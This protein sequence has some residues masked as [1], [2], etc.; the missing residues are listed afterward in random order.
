MRLSFFF[1]LLFISFYLSAQA[2]PKLVLKEKPLPPLGTYHLYIEPSTPRYLIEKA[3]SK[4]WQVAFLFDQ[5]QAAWLREIIPLLNG[6]SPLI[7]LEGTLSP[8]EEIR[9]RETLD[10]FNYEVTLVHLK[11]K[12]DD[13]L[14]SLPFKGVVTLEQQTEKGKTV[15]TLRRG[16]QPSEQA[17]LLSP[18]D[19]RAFGKPFFVAAGLLFPRH[20]FRFV[21]IEKA[22]EAKSRT[23]DL[24]IVFSTKEKD[25]EKFIEKW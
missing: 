4:K 5:Q 21:S 8:M 25:L 18:L 20:G 3:L 19:E 6:T 17:T 13:T 15:F 11:R 2:A 24:T 1:T 16:K 22:N 12:K 10:F 7:F 9:L 23:G 14:P